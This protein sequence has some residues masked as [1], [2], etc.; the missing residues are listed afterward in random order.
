MG[1][2]C[3]PSV[4]QMRNMR[5]RRS[6]KRGAQSMRTAVAFSSMSIP[7]KMAILAACKARTTYRFRAAV[8]L[9]PRKE[10]GDNHGDQDEEACDPDERVVTPRATRRAMRYKFTAANVLPIRPTRVVLLRQAV[11][12]PTRREHSMLTI[13]E[14]GSARVWTYVVGSATTG[15]RY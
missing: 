14:D 4:R 5:D 15:V 9:V 13:D 3:H 2:S 8:E 12:D 10:N 1:A 11:H 6:A 7:Q